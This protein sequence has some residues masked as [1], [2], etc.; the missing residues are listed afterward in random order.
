LRRLVVLMVLLDRLVALCAVLV[1]LVLL[2]LLLLALHLHMLMV[3][4]ELLSL[5]SLK[6]RKRRGA[7]ELTPRG[8]A[9]TGSAGPYLL[10]ELLQLLELPLFVHLAQ[11]QLL[12]PLDELLSDLLLLLRAQL[13]VPFA[14]LGLAEN[15]N[16]RCE[17]GVNS[18]GGGGTKEIEER[19]KSDKRAKER[20]SCCC[21]R[22]RRGSNPRF[23]FSSSR[24]V[25]GM[26]GT[27]AT[28]LEGTVEGKLGGRC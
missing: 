4:L 18:G 9:E 19:T 24:Q 3:L 20:T 14:P 25:G 17:Y 5:K 7:C 10:L 8:S 23:W 15:E 13:H 12:P 22:T 27:G 16:A 6:K 11:A 28:V 26:A 21:C 1:V 2:C